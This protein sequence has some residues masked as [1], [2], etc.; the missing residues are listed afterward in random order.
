MRDER[1]DPEE[2]ASS[3][4]G[5]ADEQLP[6]CFDLLIAQTQWFSLLNSGQR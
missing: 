5:E 6:I 3:R 4:F 2:E 1:E